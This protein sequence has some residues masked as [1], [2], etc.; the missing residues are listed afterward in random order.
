MKRLFPVFLMACLFSGCASDMG[1]G[2]SKSL[3]T[4]T[5]VIEVHREDIGKTIQARLDQ[6]IFFNFTPYPDRLGQW[7]VKEYTNRTLL[8]LSDTPRVPVAN[9]GALLQA[10][11]LGSAEVTLTF[12][13]YSET[14]PER[15][16]GEMPDA[17]ATPR[18]TTPSQPETVT[19]EISITR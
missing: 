1:R 19:F 18:S 17:P 9:W 16:T 3:Y 14:A 2:S 12:T 10:R 15:A 6:K 5:E 8:M 7:A 4:V 11:A 13:P